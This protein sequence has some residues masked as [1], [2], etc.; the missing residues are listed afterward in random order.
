MRASRV[1]S[2]GVITAATRPRARGAGAGGSAR[3]EPPPSSSPRLGHVVDRDDARDPRERRHGRDR[4]VQEVEPL[5]ARSRRA[6]G[7]RARARGTR[8]AAP[9]RRGSGPASAA[10]ALPARMITT[11]RTSGATSG[12]VSASRRA[13][14]STPVSG[15]TSRHVRSRPMPSARAIPGHG[16]GLSSSRARP[17]RHRR[18]RATEEMIGTVGRELSSESPPVA[19]A[20]ATAF[21]ARAARTSLRGVADQVDVAVREPVQAP[22]ARARPSRSARARRGPGDRRRTRRAWKKSPSRSRESLIRAPSRTLPVTSPSVTDVVGGEPGRAD[23]GLPGRTSDGPPSTSRRR[24][25]EIAV[26]ERS[27][28]REVC[29]RPARSPRR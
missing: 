5:A 21:A 19:T 9:A 2:E 18:A 26:D 4:R 23:R 22:A 12:S 1:D 14:R 13:A 7:S 24:W 15:T 8:T 25:S 17:A 27:G 16:A 6:A 20:T 28:V 10:R 11:K 3:A 29:R